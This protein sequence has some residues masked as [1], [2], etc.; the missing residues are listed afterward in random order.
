MSVRPDHLALRSQAFSLLL[1]ALGPVHLMAACHPSRSTTAGKTFYDAYDRVLELMSGIDLAADTRVVGAA[2]QA[3]ADAARASVGPTLRRFFHGAPRAVR[4]SITS[5]GSCFTIRLSYSPGRVPFDANAPVARR[6]QRG[7]PSVPLRV[8]SGR[9]A[10]R[11]KRAQTTEPPKQEVL[12]QRVVGACMGLLDVLHAEVCRALKEL[13]AAKERGGEAGGEQRGDEEVL[14]RLRQALR[15]QA[16]EDWFGAAPDEPITMVPSESGKSLSSWALLALAEDVLA[17]EL[18]RLV[19]QHNGNVTMACQE[20]LLLA[21]ASEAWRKAH[22]MLLGC[23]QPPWPPTSPCNLP[24]Q[25][26]EGAAGGG[27]GGG[28][29]GAASSAL[30]PQAAHHHDA[31][32]GCCG[33]VGAGAAGGA[34]ASGGQRPGCVAR[35][36]HGLPADKTPTVKS[37]GAWRHNVALRLSVALVVQKLAATPMHAKVRGRFFVA[38]LLYLLTW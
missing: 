11:T 18:E 10:T 9:M 1:D 4:P 30:P 34:S 20:L 26:A 14:N 24:L 2:V 7:A 29:A 8:M 13:A 17:R 31:V 38:L 35:Q 19:Q 16:A 23:P 21:C 15:R 25:Q 32:G 27:G 22:M 36:Q 28:A 5:D 3:A 12:R 6:R 37:S 33:N